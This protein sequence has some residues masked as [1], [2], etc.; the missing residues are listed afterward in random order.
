MIKKLD[1]KFHRLKTKANV[2]KMDDE[3]K[4]FSLQVTQKLETSTDNDSKL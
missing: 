1:E 3:E 4:G 2:N